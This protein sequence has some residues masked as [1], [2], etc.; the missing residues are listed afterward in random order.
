MTQ[1]TWDFDSLSGEVVSAESA[2]AAPGAVNSQ[3]SQAIGESIG[4]APQ[5]PAPSDSHVPLPGGIYW[6]GELLKDA[7]VRE[8]TGEDE[9][10]L[11][12][13]KGSLARWVSVLLERNVVR[14]GPVTNPSPAMVRKLL[15]G[16]RDALLLGIR[17]ATLGREIT[18]HNV[19]CPHCEEF[20]DA[21]VDL[22][23]V[24][25]VTIT[26]PRPRHEY[27]VPLR[28]GRIALVRLPDGAAQE[29]MLKAES[30]TLPE[31][32]TSLLA[33]CLVQVSDASGQA[34]TPSGAALARSLGVAD[35]RQL[36]QHIHD[37]QPGPVL[38]E[39]SFE[40][41]ACGKE[42]ILPITIGELF[43]GE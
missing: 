30:A 13:V 9:E 20:F 5:P 15:I 4:D 33:Q 1:S 35:R 41:E 32:N 19:Q 14:I 21:T 27:E 37:T 2:L 29:E 11:A 42:V 36:L 25:Q 26:E 34:V 8:L 10:E 22:T 6:E 17:V 12:R 43:R 38:N 7:E 23:T 24:E 40:H 16:D 31:R 18:A 3:I 39:I 28:N